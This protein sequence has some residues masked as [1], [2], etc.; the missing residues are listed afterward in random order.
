M[1]MIE[2]SVL[3][4]S[5]NNDTSTEW[6]NI[7]RQVMEQP[8]LFGDVKPEIYYHEEIYQSYKPFGVDFKIR[9]LSYLRGDKKQLPAR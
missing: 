7:A 2:K 4:R 9:L 5:I 8:E 3:Y 1:K 6:L